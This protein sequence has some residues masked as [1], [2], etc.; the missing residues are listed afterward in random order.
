M[1]SIKVKDRIGK[2][3][4][5]LTILGIT[6]NGVGAFVE[7]VCDCGNICN[8]IGQNVFLGFTKSCGCLA[9]EIHGEK[10]PGFSHGSSIES[11]KNRKLYKSFVTHKHFCKKHGLPFQKEWSDFSVFLKEM[12]PKKS[13][14]SLL[15]M[16]LSKGFVRGNVY[17][18]KR[19]R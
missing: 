5:R 15:R 10:H 1:P 7:C 12:G 4:G 16:D 19:K 2:K 14:E 9:L 6:R 8:V 11:S 18:R 3:Y 13:N 17:Y